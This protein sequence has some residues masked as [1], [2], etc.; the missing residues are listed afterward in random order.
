MK[1]AKNYGDLADMSDTKLKKLHTKLSKE[2][3]EALIRLGY[4]T[5]I[6]SSLLECEREL[7]L[8]ETE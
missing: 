2:I 8:R 5:A 6:L 1:H 4:D 3:D 7:S